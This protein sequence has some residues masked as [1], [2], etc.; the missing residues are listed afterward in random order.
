[1]QIVESFQLIGE[2]HRLRGLWHDF[3]FLT[4]RRNVSSVRA[5][6]FVVFCS[7]VSNPQHLTG[8]RLCYKNTCN[9]KRRVNIF[10]SLL[11]PKIGPLGITAIFVQICVILATVSGERL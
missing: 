6:I 9:F 10:G 2:S 5:A 8:A 7:A 3:C 4:D 1:L 11:A